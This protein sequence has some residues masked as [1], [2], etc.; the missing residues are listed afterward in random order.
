MI[1]LAHH[2]FFAVP[3]PQE[4]KSR[5]KEECKR[6]RTKLPFHKWV[7][8]EDYHITL[9][10]LGGAD[11]K[12]VK[13]AIQAITLPLQKVSRFTLTLDCF[14]TFGSQTNPRIFWIGVEESDQLHYLRSIVFESCK[15][16]G[17]ELETR[18]F[19]PHITVARKWTGAENFHSHLLKDSKLTDTFTVDKI[20]LY[21]THLDSKPKYI[22]K[23]ELYITGE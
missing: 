11:L 16:A 1:R 5:I 7:Y 12:M 6:L 4:L 13:K 22:I 19:T 9:V 2:Y 3:L 18:P 21:E 20:V 15:K 10:F 23:E 8:E 14:G 17:F